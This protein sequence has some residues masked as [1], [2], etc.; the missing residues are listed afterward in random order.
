MPKG[1][2]ICP[3]C[4][5]Q[6]GPRSKDCKFCGAPFLYKDKKE[7]AKERKDNIE[8]A[9]EIEYNKKRQNSG[10]V[11]SSYPLILTPGK[12]T[13][14]KRPFCPQ[15]LGGY[16]VDNVLDWLD[17]MKNTTVRANENLPHRYSRSAIIYM[18]RCFYNIHSIEYSTVR[19]II[20]RN[21]KPY[22]EELI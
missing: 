17:R 10:G 14:D 8:K 11:L 16:D 6:C 18:I 21:M 2:K 20:C 13:W 5:K 15:P 9:K 22:A 19:D 3:S 7:K 12:H 1:F 4:D